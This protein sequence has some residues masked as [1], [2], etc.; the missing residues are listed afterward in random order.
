M[1]RD[2]YWRVACKV[3]V[4]YG[5]N[6]QL[7][8]ETL[9]SVAASHPDI[10]QEEPNRPIVLFKNFGESSLEFELWCIISEVNRKYIITSEL[11]Y[12]INQAFRKN[13][14]TI[15]FPQRDIHIKDQP[16]Y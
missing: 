9:L 14:I 13:G 7:V 15:A 12:A 11:N 2:R 10:E 6:T 16:K 8:K 1:F 5:S 4:A 3:G